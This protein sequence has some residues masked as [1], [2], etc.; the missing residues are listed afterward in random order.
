[1]LDIFK[2]RGWIKAKGKQ[3]TDSTHVM[4][5]IR[6]LGRLEQ[7]G[8]TLRHALNVLAEAEPDWLLSQVPS[9]WFDRYT[10]RFEE[11]RLP[12]KKTEQHQM[13]V[14]IAADGYA[15]LNAVYAE[16]ALTTLRHLTAVQTLRQ[17]WVQQFYREAD[18]IR[19]REE[20]E[21]PTAAERINTTF[22]TEARY[23]IK[24]DLTWTGYKIFL[25]ETYDPEQPRLITQVSTS[26]ATTQDMTLTASIRADPKSK[27]LLPSEQLVDARFLD[28][29]L[30]VS[31]QQDCGIDLVGPIG[32]NGSWQSKAG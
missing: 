25:T 16:H 11:A 12:S 3:R 5:A 28:A 15:L 30:L 18:T 2:E 13:A 9:E 19:W 21:M 20:Q 4:G 7:A 24:G 8:E 29:D 31:S 17:V 26:P 32:R 27:D 23:S 1:L 22:D 14:V 10:R 6:V